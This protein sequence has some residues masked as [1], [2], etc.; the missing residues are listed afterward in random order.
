M[1]QMQVFCL[2]ICN[3]QNEYYT[4]LTVIVTVMEVQ[5]EA[6]QPEENMEFKEFLKMIDFNGAWHHHICS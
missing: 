3:P 2:N 1:F 5:R 6:Q 4:K